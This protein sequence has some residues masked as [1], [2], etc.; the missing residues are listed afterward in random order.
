MK[1][2]EA[3]AITGKQVIQI[4]DVLCD[5]YE[6]IKV[7]ISNGEK[8]SKWARKRGSTLEAEGFKL[9]SLGSRDALSWFHNAMMEIRN[10]ILPNAKVSDGSTPTTQPKQDA[11][12][13]SEDLPVSNIFLCKPIPAPKWK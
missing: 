4:L 11:Q 8:Q 2:S 12:S 1:K 6:A 13:R 3:T 10:D 7:D 9:R 5:A